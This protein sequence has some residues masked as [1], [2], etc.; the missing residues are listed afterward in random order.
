MSANCLS[1]RDF[2]ERL[3]TVCEREH[4]SRIPQLTAELS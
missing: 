1:L 2:E 3:R 4:V